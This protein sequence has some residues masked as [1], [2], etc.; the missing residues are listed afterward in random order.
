MWGCFRV[1]FKEGESKPVFPTHV[2]VFLKI[3]CAPYMPSS[4][5]HACGGVSIFKRGRCLDLRSCA[6]LWG[7]FFTGEKNLD[8]NQVFP[9]HVGV[10]PILE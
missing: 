7:S 10:F 5:P 2:G 3:C 4:L 9:T 1:R 8:F 6:R